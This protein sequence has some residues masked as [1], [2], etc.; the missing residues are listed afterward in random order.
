MKILAKA[1]TPTKPA[2][3]PTVP[4]KPST[5][6]EGF[7]YHRETAPDFPK[8]VPNVLSEAQ[9][10]KVF[11]AIKKKEA[12]ATQTFYKGYAMSRLEPR[13]RVGSSTYALGKWR[14]PQG[15]AEHYVLKHRVK[16]SDAF[17]E[18]LG[19]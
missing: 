4:K 3:K 7:W 15:Y 8:P 5:F 9:A 2:A 10:K 11:A 14:W 12:K 19:L 13:V 18:F 17:L 1:K 16:P 6:L